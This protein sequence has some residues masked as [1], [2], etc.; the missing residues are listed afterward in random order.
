[1]IS[2]TGSAELSNVGVPGIGKPGA[3]E[4]PSSAKSL[5]IGKLSGEGQRGQGQQACSRSLR[6][7]LGTSMVVSR[8]KQACP[9]TALPCERF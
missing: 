5:G 6:G 7:T 3:K 2:T 4:W 8:S 1:M 9:C